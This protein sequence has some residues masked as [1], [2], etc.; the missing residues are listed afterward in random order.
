MSTQWRGLKT[1]RLGMVADV[2]ICSGGASA[3]L[4]SATLSRLAPSLTVA[5][6]DASR[7]PGRGL[8]YGVA[9]RRHVLNTRAERMSVWA[10]DPMHFVHW[11]N[12]HRGR[13]GRAWEG[14]DFAWR[15]DYGDYLIDALAGL[16]RVAVLEGRAVAAARE[17]GRWRVT[18]EDQRAVEASVLVLATGNRAPAPIARDSDGPDMR[19]IEDPWDPLAMTAVPRDLPVAVLGAGL[20][21]VD[22]ALELIDAGRTAPIVMISRRG[23]LPGHHRSPPRL[24]PWLKPPFPQTL[25]ALVRGVRLRLAEVGEDPVLR[26]GVIDSIRPIVSALWRHAPQA[27][28]RRFLRHVRPFW[29]SERHRV[30]PFVWDRIAAAKRAGLIGQMRGRLTRIDRTDEGLL[31]SF[32]SPTGPWSRRFGAIVNC[33]GPDYAPAT[34]GDLLLD[35]LRETDAIRADAFEQ[36]IDVDD[37]ARAIWADGRVASDLYTLGGLTRGVF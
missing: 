33:T 20:T 18:L 24:E 9:A 2:A 25:G 8:A 10:D 13:D 35:S 26:H 12:R 14:A 34:D 19:I 11:L 4:L 17:P 5:V 3:V 27:E 37:D 30:A 31:V 16:G 28:R 23:L 22:I 29:D 6:I 15:V 36:G 32:G 7:T 21:A 1:G